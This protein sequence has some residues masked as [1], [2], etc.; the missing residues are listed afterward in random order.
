MLF[1]YKKYADRLCEKII[2]EDLG[3]F[4]RLFSAA[5]LIIQQK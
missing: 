1:V 2:N 3:A 5:Y 4:D